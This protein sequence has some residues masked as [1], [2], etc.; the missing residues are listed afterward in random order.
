LAR[1]KQG[2]LGVAD[3]VPVYAQI[4]HHSA[5][6]AGEP[7]LGFFTDARKFLRAELATDLFYGIDGVTLHYDIYNIEAEA[8]GARLLWEEGQI[9]VVD[10]RNPLLRSVEDVGSLLPVRIGA[11]ARMPFVLEVNARL[12]DLGLAPKVRFTGL[13][14]LAASL[15]GLEVLLVAILERPESVHRLMRHLTTD[16]VAPWIACQR[17]RCGSEETATGSDALASPPLTSIDI[18]REFCL[19]YIEELEKLVGRVR[20]AGLWGEASLREPRALLDIKRA[21]SPASIQVLD[22]D[23]TLLGPSYFRAYASETGASLVVGLD[24]NL[25]GRGTVAEVE[26]RATRFIEEAGRTGRFV[27]FMNDV[28]FDAPTENVRA[29]IRTAR[30]YR[31]DPSGERYERGPVQEEPAVSMHQALRALAPLLG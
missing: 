15:V 9:P 7:T 28:P 13:F 25:I 2:A 30:S 20:L 8:L 21:G 19:Q 23:V 4:S 3:A 18:V 27:L 26:C 31:A 1:A 10:S 17:D 22:P 6:L 16:V 11:A 14:T 12:M 29:V 5:R 24:A